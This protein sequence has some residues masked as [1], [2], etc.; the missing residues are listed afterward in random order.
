MLKGTVNYEATIKGNGISF[1]PL[2]FNPNEPGVDKVEIECPNGDAIRLRVHFTAVASDEKAKGLAAKVGVAAVNR[3]A[4]HH[5]V[6][7][8]NDRIQ[9]LT[10]TLVV[11]VWPRPRR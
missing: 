2:E 8:V 4:F 6:V 10:P 11:L 3:I 7:I 5:K 1:P 9:L